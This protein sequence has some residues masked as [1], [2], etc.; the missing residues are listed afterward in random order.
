M[1]GRNFANMLA[2]LDV[3]GGTW[4][5]PDE[6]PESFGIRGQELAKGFVGQ[7]VAPFTDVMRRRGE[8]AKHGESARGRFRITG[9]PTVPD[10]AQ[11]GEPGGR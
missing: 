8:R 2:V 4:T 7:M 1:A 3:L 11:A 10:A 9:S 5:V 6:R